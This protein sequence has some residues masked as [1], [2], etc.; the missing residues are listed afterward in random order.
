LPFISLLRDEG[1]TAI[2]DCSD[3]D[4]A[5]KRAAENANGRALFFLFEYAQPAFCQPLL[6]FLFVQE[7]QIRRHR[8]SLLR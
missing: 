6:P 3:G 2:D 5:L 8:H 1:W 7:L 4:G